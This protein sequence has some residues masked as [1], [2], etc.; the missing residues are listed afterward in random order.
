MNK[1]AESVIKWALIAITLCGCLPIWEVWT[2]NSWEASQSFCI[3]P[4][5]TLGFANAIQE[6]GFWNAATSFYTVNFIMFTFICCIGGGLG[7]FLSKDSS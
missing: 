1:R 5:A 4:V 3:L 6:E 7:F 2:F